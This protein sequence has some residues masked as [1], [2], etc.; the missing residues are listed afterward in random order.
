MTH[1][2]DCGGDLSRAPWPTS[3]DGC[4]CATRA[5]VRAQR[6]YVGA[7]AARGSLSR[8]E[9]AAYLRAGNHSPG[10]DDAVGER[11]TTEAS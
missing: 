1:C 2:A 7:V 11:A 4:I 9:Y 3:R 6:G 5:T 10:P 8:E